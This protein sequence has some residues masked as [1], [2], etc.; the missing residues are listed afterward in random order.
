MFN[1]ARMRRQATARLRQFMSKDPLLHP[2]GRT[3]DGRID[4]ALAVRGW[5]RDDLFRAGR[6]LAPHRHRIAAML[7]A[8]ELVA[9]DIV[10]RHW[11]QLKVA[12]HLCARC[13][14]KWRCED[15]L[16]G[17][18][19][20]DTP[21]KFCPNSMTFQHW[22]RANFFDESMPVASRKASLRR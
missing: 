16:W 9:N 2:L 21:R 17:K 1:L 20:G 3:P 19:P 14:N 4:A 5:R 11:P 6:T 22:R 12:D 8:Q 13:V 10:T 15:W 7:L 18:R